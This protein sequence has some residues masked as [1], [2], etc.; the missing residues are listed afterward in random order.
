MNLEQEI[1][2]KIT[3]KGKQRVNRTFSLSV[4]AVRQLKEIAE[5]RFNDDVNACLVA[6][7]QVA[8]EV[9]LKYLKLARAQKKDDDSIVDL[10]E[11]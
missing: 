1:A 8:F 7:I 5:R 11:I 6:I 4:S 3:T 2:E 9:D 10:I